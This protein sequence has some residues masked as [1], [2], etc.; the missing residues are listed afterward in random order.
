M[1]NIFI[2]SENIPLRNVLKDYLKIEGYKVVASEKAASS[3]LNFVIEENPDLVILDVG[4]PINS[5]IETLI[6]IKSNDCLKHKPVFITTGTEGIRAKFN[7][8][9]ETMISG[10]LERPF[11]IEVLLQKI[12]QVFGE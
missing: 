3:P 2:I 9:S 10:F 6:N 8:N 1:K 11:K 5:G 7:K 12:D 4:M